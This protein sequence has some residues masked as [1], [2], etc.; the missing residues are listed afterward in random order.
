[1][2][3]KYRT[4]HQDPDTGEL[5][6]EDLT[7]EEFEEEA[8]TEAEFEQLEDDEYYGRRS[9]GPRP[10]VRPRRFR[11]RKVGRVETMPRV[12][13][14]QNLKDATLDT[15]EENRET[16]SDLLYRLTKE[17]LWRLGIGLRVKGAVV[18]GAKA[19]GRAF[20]RHILRMV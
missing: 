20:K 12:T 18:A 17:T 8:I 4:F 19:V 15:F 10:R 13:E 16:I 9:R 6:E 11:G 2:A 1:V 7:E 5:F 3:K 14:P